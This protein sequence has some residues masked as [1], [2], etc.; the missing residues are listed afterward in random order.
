M[1]SIFKIIVLSELKFLIL[2]LLILT[3]FTSR[4]GENR[5]DLKVYNINAE[6]VSEMRAEKFSSDISVFQSFDS[7]TAE[8]ETISFN[9]DT[10]KNILPIPDTCD[11]P[12]QEN[13]HSTFHQISNGERIMNPSA[14]NKSFNIYVSINALCY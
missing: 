9:N 11:T 3:F 10:I 14:N 13:I 4:A 1:Y 8:K 7:I 5:N 12:G 6:D 2:F